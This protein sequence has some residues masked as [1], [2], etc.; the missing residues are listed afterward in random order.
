MIL[1]ESSKQSNQVLILFS[2]LGILTVTLPWIYYPRLDLTLYGHDGDGVM[3]SILFSIIFFVQLYIFFKK[4]TQKNKGYNIACGVISTLILI[5][6]IYKIKAFYKEVYE[7]VSNDPIVSYSGAGAR[8]E[9]GLNVIVIF[10]FICLVTSVFGAYMKS[11]KH[12]IFALVVCILVGLSTWFVIQKINAPDKLD[13]IEIEENLASHFSTMSKA[14]IS[15]QTNEFVEYI[16]PILYQS[17]GGKRKLAELMTELYTDVTVKSAKIDK[18]YKTASDGEAIQVLLLQSIVI[19][20]GAQEVE[21]TNKSLA[22]S[23]DGGLNWKFAGIEDRSFDEMRKILPEL[24]EEL[25][26]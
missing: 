22:F 6:S 12:L 21:N 14:L 16:H 23:Y 17:I 7:F 5:L 9:Y 8:L 3:V 19:Q 4:K 2:M 26:Y 15:K 10:S 25:R 13:K 11:M 18:I 1:F 20:N 24:K